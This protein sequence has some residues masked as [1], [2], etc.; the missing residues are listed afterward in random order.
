MARFEPKVKPDSQE[1]VEA[2]EAE[3]AKEVE[4][5]MAQRWRVRMENQT[6][7]LNSPHLPF[8]H[9]HSCYQ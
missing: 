9:F 4:S 3:L 5:T 7:H 1:V 8:C 2:I 6:R